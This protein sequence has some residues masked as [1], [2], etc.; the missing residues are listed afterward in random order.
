MNLP[1]A[2]SETPGP[3]I[4]FGKIE[5]IKLLENKYQPSLFSEGALC[6]A[7]FGKIEK[8]EIVEKK[9]IKKSTTVIHSG[10]PHWSSQK[11][12]ALSKR[13][14]TEGGGGGRAKRSSIRRPQRST[15]CCKSLVNI[16]YHSSDF[17]SLECR[18]FLQKVSR[19]GH[20]SRECRRQ[21][22]R[23]APS[24]APKIA[25]RSPNDAPRSPQDGPRS[26]QEAPRSAQDAP[27]AS[28]ERPRAA[29]SGPRAVQERP[30][31]AKRALGTILGPSCGILEPSWDR[32]CV[33]FVTFSTVFCKLV[34]LHSHRFRR[35]LGVVSSGQERPKS[36]QETLKRSPRAPQSDPRA[37][38]ERPR[39]AQEWPKSGSR[40]AKSDQERPNSGQETP[41]GEPELPR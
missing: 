11:P 30:R 36:G 32:K 16:P 31:A 2:F 25:P 26:P 14:N 5:K 21:P 1:Q 20:P 22:S 28:Q 35:H 4:S 9:S 34:F 29:R 7:D 24:W 8:F 13:S 38:Q 12:K 27:G 19:G 18:Y 10:Y 17:K 33:F 40:A 39:A 37:S 23:A 41:K 3:I 15:A 6:T